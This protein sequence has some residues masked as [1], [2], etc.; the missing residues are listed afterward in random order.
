M[1]KTIT[2]VLKERGQNRGLFGKRRRIVEAIEPA[3]VD[4]ADDA[5][6]GMDDEASGEA[7]AKCISDLVAAILA[8][9]NLDFATKREKIDKLLDMLDDSGE[10][11]A[12]ESLRRK[13]RRAGIV[14][15]ESRRPGRRLRESRLPATAQQ[16][17][18]FLFGTRRQTVSQKSAAAA[19]V[20]RL[21]G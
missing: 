2:A 7:L 19:Q 12:A 17:I 14:V 18:D 21:L 1:S 4:I 10:T 16:Q 15:R 20:R 9:Q 3:A 5:D 13:S 11:E 6:D 8:N